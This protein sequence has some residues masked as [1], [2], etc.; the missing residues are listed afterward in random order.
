MSSIKELMGFLENEK[1]TAD[2]VEQVMGE[3]R[4]AALDDLNIPVGVSVENTLNE[5]N[6]L[7]NRLYELH[8]KQK[9]DPTIMSRIVALLE[10]KTKIVGMLNIKPD[11][12]SIIDSEINTYKRRFLELATLCVD[13]TT[14]DVL[15]EKLSKEGL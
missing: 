15:T 8:N 1:I 6:M 14:M 11:M 2:D 12:Q 13:K 3:A 5:L 7:S 4:D 9:R 10:L